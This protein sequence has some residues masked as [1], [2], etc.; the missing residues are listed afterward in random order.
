MGGKENV[1]MKDT[2]NITRQKE[3]ENFHFGTN[4]SAEEEAYLESLKTKAN[5]VDLLSPPDDDDEYLPYD[6]E[7]EWEQDLLKPGSNPLFFALSYSASFDLVSALID[8]G[9]KDLVLEKGSS[10]KDVAVETTLHAALRNDAS[11]NVILKLLEVGGK[12]AVM[13]KKD[14]YNNALHWVRERGEYD[15]RD[16]RD[17]RA[18]IIREPNEP[19][20]HEIL[21]KIIQLGGMEVIF[22]E[23]LNI[24]RL[25]RIEFE[26]K[27]DQ[28][29]FHL[30]IQHGGA[31]LLTKTDKTGKTPLQYFIGTQ[32]DL[33]DS[34]SQ[35]YNKL[36]NGAAMLMNKAIETS[37]QIGESG[38]Y[39]IG[40]L[41]TFNSKY[42]NEEVKSNVYQNW[43]DI[44]LPALEQVIVEVPQEVPTPNRE[45]LNINLPI[46]QAL[47]ANKAPM[48]I[49]MRTKD[50]F[51]ESINTIDSFGRYPIDAVARYGLAWDGMEIFLALELERSGSGSRSTRTHN[52]VDYFERID[53]S[54]GL[55]PF[56]IAAV[57]EGEENENEYKY[58]YKYEYEYDVGTVFQMIQN[59]P[60]LVRKQSNE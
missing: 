34:L 35:D 52:D 29:W 30:L 22:A 8:V 17:G 11:N 20:N 43:D 50:Y 58:E 46:L 9:G 2:T 59:R 1:F 53:A 36:I 27:M 47:I 45:N 28:D 39:S 18:R 14:W 40:G 37:S 4:L 5:Y 16:E 49:I 41:F 55:Y 10:R 31:D 12:E 60:L 51:P 32:V 54:T 56:M 15:E 13:E 3:M 26:P 42:K 38:E 48:E 24:C 33:D 21:S 7:D 25:A 23:L 6:D 44:V 19:T 57:G